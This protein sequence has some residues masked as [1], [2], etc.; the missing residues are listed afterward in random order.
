MIEAIMTEAT[1]TPTSS[2]AARAMRHRALGDETRLAV[3]DAL[4][5]SDRSPKELGELAAAPPNLL[6]FHLK[7]LEEAGLITR[8]ASQG[9]ARRRYVTLVRDRLASLSEP[10]PLDAPAQRV[11]FVCTANSARSQLAAH[12]WHARTGLPA[13]SAGTDPA[14][15]V[16]PSAVDVARRRGLD[17]ADAEPISYR[18]VDLRPDLVVS[19]CDRAHESEVGL[20]APSLH[21]SVPDPVGG[22]MEAFV[23]TFED[24]AARIDGLARALPRA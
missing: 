14:P 10:R 11:L 5:L 21:W 7:V 17:L 24:L 18:E 19:V 12:L 2:L 13:L 9:D 16:H 6:A 8:T 4:Q 1:A 22:H 3:V 23:R 20:D 15:H